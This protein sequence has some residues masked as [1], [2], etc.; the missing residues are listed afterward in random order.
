MLHIPVGGV[1]VLLGSVEWWLGVVFGLGFLVYEVRQ[2][3]I[4]GDADYK[5]I[6]GWLWGIGIAGGIWF[7][8]KVMGVM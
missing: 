6:V 4:V 3:K 2:H 1:T 8:L 7:V 5:D